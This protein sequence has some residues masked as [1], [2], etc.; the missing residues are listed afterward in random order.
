MG[1]GISEAVLTAANPT[2]AEKMGWDWTWGWIIYPDSTAQGEEVKPAR[3]AG[4]L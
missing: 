3:A 1:Q 2:S 4:V